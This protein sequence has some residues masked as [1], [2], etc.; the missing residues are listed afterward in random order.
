ML[1][2]KRFMLC[3]WMFVALSF[4]VCRVIGVGAASEVQRQ[5]VVQEALVL[6]LNLCYSTHIEHT[7][8]STLS[9]AVHRATHVALSHNH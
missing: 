4:S 6:S 1:Q 9:D 2:E 8:V 7:R 5:K 3:A